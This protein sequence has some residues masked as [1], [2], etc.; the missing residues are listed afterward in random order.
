[1]MIPIHHGF[2]KAFHPVAVSSTRM[3]PS[4]FFPNKAFSADFPQPKP[5]IT[6]KKREGLYQ[7]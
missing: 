2:C 6:P 1:M 5:T 3:D 4:F 7:I